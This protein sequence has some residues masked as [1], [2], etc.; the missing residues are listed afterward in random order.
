MRQWRR[1]PK[2]LFSVQYAILIIKFCVCLIVLVNS[3]TSLIKPQKKKKNSKDFH[4]NPVT[5][6]PQAGNVWGEGTRAVLLLSL[7]CKKIK[8]NIEDTPRVINYLSSLFLWFCIKTPIQF[9]KKKNSNMMTACEMLC[10]FCIQIS[11]WNSLT[12]WWKM[13]TLLPSTLLMV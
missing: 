4:L 3:V 10:S 6:L 5:S 13:S 1:C 11:T 9:I 8:I 2:Y 12:K 7:V